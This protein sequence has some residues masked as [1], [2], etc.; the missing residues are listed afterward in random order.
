M[1]K[2]YTFIS[3]E[4]KCLYAECERQLG[5]KCRSE[6]LP[7]EPGQEAR[8]S[9]HSGGRER[10]LKKK[11]GELNEY[12]SSKEP[13]KEQNYGAQKQPVV[14]WSTYVPIILTAVGETGAGG[15]ELFI[16]LLHLLCF[17]LHVR[18]H[19][20]LCPV[21]LNSTFRLSSP[22]QFYLLFRLE[23]L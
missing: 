15:A 19:L 2:V 5:Q 3:S 20:H 9:D 23:T 4:L 10:E 8:E 12:L 17:I 7:I 6:R 18:C 14:S 21:W 1:E 13:I 22:L 16:R 11:S